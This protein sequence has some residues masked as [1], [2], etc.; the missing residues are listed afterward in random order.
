MNR[1]YTPNRPRPRSA[2]E[3]VTLDI[4]AHTQWLNVLRHELQVEV[5]RARRLC[6][7]SWHLLQQFPDFNCRPP[8]GSQT[9]LDG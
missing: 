4:R 2:Q 9:E 3:R 5:D 7:D 1:I 6:D 8:I